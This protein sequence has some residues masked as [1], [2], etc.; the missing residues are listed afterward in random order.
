MEMWLKEIAEKRFRLLPKNMG[1]L[2]RIK[3][4]GMVFDIESFDAEGVGSICL[5]RMKGM[6]G[7]IRMIS[8]T[9]TP[10][11]LD[12][13]IFSMDW[14][15]A[16]GRETL[17]LELFDTM[18]SKR[19]FPEL[20]EVKKKH[21]GLPVYEPK[22]AWYSDLHLPASAFYKGR[23]IGGELDQLVQE[24]CEGYFSALLR[25]PTCELAEKNRKNSVLPDGLLANGGLAVDQFKKMIGEEKTAQFMT[26]FMFC[27]K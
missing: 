16:F 11:K 20:E 1:D 27:C 21:E 17:L 14:I 26:Q 25:C 5:M 4:R 15:H 9:F 2:S 12:G 22:E 19:S 18:I 8:A 10:T 13:P 6:A 24:Y 23:G 3:G 7:L